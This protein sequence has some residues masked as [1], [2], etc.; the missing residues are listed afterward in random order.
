MPP[1]LLTTYWDQLYAQ[2]TPEQSS[3]YQPYP[4]VSLSLFAETGLP[5]DAPIVDVGSG[6]S[7]F[8]NELLA[9]GYFNLIATD[10][11]ATALDQHCRAL[12][13]AQAERV[14]WV[15]DDVTASEHLPLLD[16]VLLWH[17]RGLLHT[18]RSP[19]QIATY[20]RLL[21]HM[22]D[23]HGWVLLA[24]RAPTA[25]PVST[26]DAG[27]LVQPYTTAEIAALLGPSY[28][29]HTAREETHQPPQGALQP[30]THVL[31]RRNDTRREGK[32]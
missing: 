11:S 17:D 4:T 19:A 12:P 22:V 27:L 31:F 14:L 16:P 13:S 30:Y 32:W 7:P 10:C 21:H 28:T 23:A 6:L 5:F 20:C 25:A 24:V 18:L 2:R 8:L 15:V 3:W 1:S 29:L 9:Q 26:P